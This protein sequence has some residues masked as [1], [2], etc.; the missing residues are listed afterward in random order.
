MLVT[1]TVAH[2]VFVLTYSGGSAPDFHRVPCGAN[3]VAPVNIIDVQNAI[4]SYL[5]RVLILPYNIEAG[6]FQSGSRFAAQ[7]V[8]CRR[9][10]SF[11]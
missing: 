1:S 4:Y 10:T 5:L 7:N 8:Q 11:W 6:M 3:T 9:M 2:A